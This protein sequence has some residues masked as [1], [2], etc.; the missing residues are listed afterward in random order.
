[1]PSSTITSKGQT[2]VPSQVRQ[3]LNLEAGHRIEWIISPDGQ[4]T[5]KAANASIT[6]LRGLIKPA[7]KAVGLDEMDEA[8]PE[9]AAK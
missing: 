7:G 8:L 1:M 5:I 3:L 4:V 6:R 2:T 9:E